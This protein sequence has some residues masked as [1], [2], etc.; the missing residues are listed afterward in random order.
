MILGSEKA[1]QQPRILH[2][3]S[4]QKP[5]A[6]CLAAD[7]FFLSCS[8]FFC[9]CSIAQPNCVFELVCLCQ[10]PSGVSA[11]SQY[12]SGQKKASELEEY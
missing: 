4:A 3:M 6:E 10:A 2:I 7:S 9:L 5:I 1:R 12:N 11:H 8:R